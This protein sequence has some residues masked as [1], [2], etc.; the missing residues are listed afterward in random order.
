MLREQQYKAAL[1]YHTL[2]KSEKMSAFVQNPE[3]RSPSV[4]TA[5][6]AEPK[7]ISEYFSEKLNIQV[8]SGYGTMKET[9]LRIANFP[10]TSKEV[11]EM[12][13]DAIEKLD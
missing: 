8:G 9:Q 13:C 12:L 5:V 2:E 10:A 4:I 7:K 6:C 3:F 1:L 11:V